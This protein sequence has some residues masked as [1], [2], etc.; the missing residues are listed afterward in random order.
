MAKKQINGYIANFQTPLK[1]NISYLLWP[2]Y[3]D[4]VAYGEEKLVQFKSS[5]S[6]IKNNFVMAFKAGFKL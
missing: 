4:N 5:L 3:Y 2:V 6:I 1:Y